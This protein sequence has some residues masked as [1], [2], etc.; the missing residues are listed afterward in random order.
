[1]N[2]IPGLLS[3]N[4]KTSF[5]QEGSSFAVTLPKA[6]ATRL[7]KHRA[8]G[9]VLGIRPEHIYATRP[10]DVK[11]VAKFKAQIEVV[12]PVGNET[13]VYFST[14]PA[15]HL[16]ARVATDTPPAVGSTKELLIDTAKMHFFDSATE[17]AL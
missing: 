15:T 2:F 11:D 16:V 1:M 3:T 6:A 5:K 4:G 17:L 7:K 13:F 9:L 12:E 8:A 14:G 10:A